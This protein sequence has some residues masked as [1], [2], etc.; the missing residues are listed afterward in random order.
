[1]PSL[2]YTAALSAMA[3]G[4]IEFDAD[5]F[6]CVLLNDS[7]VPNK[8]HVWRSELTGLVPASGSYPNDGLAASVSVF[9]D[10]VNNRTDIIL[11]EI[12]TP[13]ATISA[14]YGIYYK[15]RGGVPEDDELVA[16]IDFG[17]N[18]VSTM[19]I[20]TLTASTLRMVN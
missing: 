17:G 6:K 13:A 3:R 20:W 2:V 18:V 19:G 14:R 5:T 16:C 12:L 11:G 8:N 15:S 7:Y 4:D 10:T 9:L 1:M